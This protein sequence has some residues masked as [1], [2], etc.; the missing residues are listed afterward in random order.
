MAEL[1]IPNIGTAFLSG[2]D[3]SQ[4][5]RSREKDIAAKQM[6]NRLL[7]MKMQYAPEQ[8]AQK[9]L[10]G[11]LELQQAY[12]NLGE[13]QRKAAA[14]AKKRV[15]TDFRTLMTGVA[16]K[17]KTMSNPMEQETLLQ[18]ALRGFTGIY[19]QDLTPQDI[20][21]FSQMNLQTLGGPDGIL[22]MFGEKETDQDYKPTKFEE[23]RADLA[24]GRINLEEYKRVIGADEKSYQQNV[25]AAIQIVNDYVDNY[26]GRERFN[27]MS[28]E[29]KQEV[30]SN[31][32]RSVQVTKAGDVPIM[33][34]AGG[35]KPVQTEGMTGTQQEIQAQISQQMAQKAA[36]IKRTELAETD[37]N[38]IIT[39]A[40]EA[41][42]QLVNL[43]K[44]QEINKKVATSGIAS[45]ANDIMDFFGVGPKE[46]GQF[47]IL[48]ANRVLELAHILR[49]VSNDERQFLFDEA[50][51]S[52]KKG[53]LS[54]AGMLEILI[55]IAERTVDAGMWLRDNPDKTPEDLLGREM[56]PLPV[57]RD[58]K[59]YIRMKQ[60]Q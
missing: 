38:Q 23:A 26:V 42:S 34:T 40:R 41:K 36:T 37:R 10:L 17:M 47:R 30:H 12:Q 18:N 55:D 60:E 8:S 14:E 59:S 6:E 58:F 28:P 49:P 24:A 54:N 16:R 25:P 22:S 33:L 39:N 11:R 3:T 57:S 2:I 45:A 46:V 35:A 27:A 43:R 32:L 4:Q 9:Q 31:A 53:E 1:M 44:F 7:Q 50:I 19:Q 20:N 48:A 29:Q 5:M 13:P 52:L 51:A 56:T 15:D 21:K